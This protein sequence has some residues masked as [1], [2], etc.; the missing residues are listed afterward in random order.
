MMKQF[1]V[2][3]EKDSEGYFV[4]S[5]PVLRGCH[6]Q[7]K[8]LDVLMERIQE[9]IEP[10]LKVEGVHFIVQRTFPKMPKWRVSHGDCFS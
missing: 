9:A 4:T 3:I 7:A 1:Y 6:T 8:S 5:V 2:V 10:C